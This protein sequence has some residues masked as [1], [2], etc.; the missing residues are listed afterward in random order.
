MDGHATSNTSGSSFASASTATGGTSTSSVTSSILAIPSDAAILQRLIK[1]GVPSEYLERGKDG[2][3]EYVKE[4]K[5]Q[6]SEVIAALLP[7]PDEVQAV[8]S[9][10]TDE[11][12]G[13]GTRKEFL[14]QCRDALKWVQWVMFQGEPQAVL[15][16]A[17]QGTGSTRGVCG[18]VWGSNDIAYRCRTCEHDPTCAICVPCF[19]NGNHASHDY[20]MIRTS[21]GCCDCGDVTA[22][23]Q[24]GFCSKH[25]GPGQVSQL[26]A[27]LVES[28]TPVLEAL[29]FQ[30][31]RT[32]KAAELVAE[33]K[34]KKWTAQSVDEKVACQLSVV[35]I[36]MLLEFCSFGEPMLAFTAEV[37]GNRSLGLVDTLMGTECFLP[38]RC[39]KHL[40]ELLYK[41]LGDTKFK[42]TFAQTFIS[43]YPACLRETFKEDAAVLGS[44]TRKKYREHSI[45]N[46]FSVQI[47]TVPTLTPKLVMEDGLLDMLLDT[48]KEFLRGCV[49]EDGRISVSKG[50]VVDRHYFRII[51]DI[52]YVMTHLE[53][54]R[55]V[56]RKRPELARAWLHLVAFVQ[57]MYPHRRITN[58]HV[59]D[60]TDIWGSAYSLE[61]QMAFIHPLFVGGAAVSSNLDPRSKDDLMSDSQ[62]DLA[63]SGSSDG[64]VFS[65]GNVN[66]VD[67]LQNINSEAGDTRTRVVDV[68]M[69]DA[70]LTADSI[71]DVS[72]ELSL[73]RRGKIE[74]ETV[75][76][77]GV[78]VSA[79]L[80]WFV[81]ECAQ[82]L[83]TWLSL[84]ASRESVKSGQLAIDASQISGIR[85]STRW[86]GRGGRGI[87]D[88]P[89]Q[90]TGGQIR[91]WL[92]RSRRL[93]FEP[94][95]WPEAATQEQ[96]AMGTNSG[97]QVADMDVEMQAPGEGFDNRAAEWW[98]GPEGLTTSNI[99]DQSVEV[100]EWPLVDF[101]V[102]RQD[103]SFHIPLHRMLALLLHK[104][105]EFHSAKQDKSFGKEKILSSDGTSG[106][107]RSF[108]EQ[109]LPRKFRVPGFAAVVMEHPL[110]LQVLC[111]QVQA[112]M[113]RRNGH[114]TRALCDLYHSVHWCEDSLE[115]DL[116][117]LQCC[118]V[119]APCEAFVDRIVARFALSDYFNFSFW[120][121]NEY[122]VTLAQELIILLIR[123]VSER[124]FCGLTEKESLR[125][126]LV[127][128][129]AVGDTTRSYL[130]KALP[131]RL[132]DSKHL[133]ECLDAVATYRNP[134]GM[135][136]GKYALRD[137]CWCELDLYHPR[138]SPRELQ[139]AEERYLRACRSPAVF[140]QLPRWSPP[141]AAL[142]G[143]G[144]LITS[145]RVHDMLR[146]IFFHAVYTDDP[147][148]SRAPEELLLYALHLLAL[149]LDVCKSPNNIGGERR[150]DLLGNNRP[151]SDIENS[152]SSSVK[153]HPPLLLRC[154][155]KVAVGRANTLVA[156]E[157]QSMLSLL[158][159]LLRK[160]RNDGASEAGSYGF[161]DLIKKLLRSF[162][163]L[164]SICMYEIELLAPEVLHRV[165]V[166]ITPKIDGTGGIDSKDVSVSESDRRKSIARERQAAAMAKMKA[167]QESFVVNYKPTEESSNLGDGDEAEA[168]RPKESRGESDEL[169]EDVQF[170][171][172][173]L[174][175]DAASASPLC[176]MVLVQRS[177]LL[178]I[179]E[180]PTP[181]WKRSLVT[182]DQVE[183][184]GESSDGVNAA[185]GV[186]SDGSRYLNS[187]AELWHWI[188]EA[189]GDAQT[190]P[191]L[192]DDEDVLELLRN[193]PGVRDTFHV[194]PEP[195]LSWD[196]AT[197]ISLDTVSEEVESG[198][199][200]AEYEND[201]EAGSVNV[202]WWE[203]NHSRVNQ[204]ES[205]T[206]R[207]KAV[208]TVLAEYVAAAVC[209]GQSRP[210]ER[211]RYGRSES[212]GHTGPEQ[213]RE[214]LTRSRRATARIPLSM[215]EAI[216]YKNSDT[217]GVHMSACGHAIHQDCRDRYFSSLLQRFYSRALFEGVQIVDLDMGE[218]LCPV[219]RR[220]ANAILPVLP[221]QTGLNS[222][223]IS[224][225]V[226]QLSSGVSSST[227]SLQVD[228]ALRLL[229]KA[230]ELVSRSE[231]RK[232]ADPQLPYNVKVVLEDLAKR[233]CGL[234]YSEKDLFTSLSSIQGHVHQGLLL[235]NVFR[236]SLM[237][238]EL[239]S[240]SQKLSENNGNGLMALIEM[241]EASHGSVLPLLLH[242]AKA[243]QSQSR[244][245]VLLR[246]RGM[247]LLV[248]SIVNGIS[249]D[250]HA[251]D[252]PR[253]LHGNYSALMQYLEKDNDSVD[254]QLWKRL[255]DP[256]LVHDA[257]SS[258][259]WLLFCLPLPFPA[260]G[261]PFI[262]L[263]H[264]F[265][266]VTI[267]QTIAQL[268][269]FATSGTELTPSARSFI[270]AVQTGSNGTVLESSTGDS[271][272]SP[273]LE[274]YLAYIRRCT[275][276]FLRRCYLLQ[277][278]L[279]GAAQV[280]PVATAHQWELPQG[281]IHSTET[282][283][284][285]ED[286]KDA[287]K[288]VLLE[289]EELDQLESVFLIPSLVN[290]FEQ[291]TNQ[292][293]VQAWC[294]H[295]KTDAGPRGIQH[296][297]R[298]TTASPFKLMQLPY[299]FQDLMQRYVKEKCPRCKTVPDK[300]AICLMC[301]ALCCA[302]SLRP[303][304]SV[305]RQGECTRHAMNCGAGIGIFLML[306]KTNILLLRCGRQAMWP[307]PYLDAFGE[308]DLELRRGK[309]LYLSRERYA[310]LTNMVVAHGLD[311]SSPVLSHT[312]R[313]IPF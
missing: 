1:C 60:E 133:Q 224:P 188:Q 109:V 244:L 223:F 309:P 192:L 204:G 46:S 298:V 107:W 118:A 295:V 67:G 18:A 48:L 305:N 209:R 149:A 97:N 17:G 32:L 203:D 139:A 290:I 186:A 5:P 116:F 194:T 257:F 237:S 263:L 128:R 216:R 200:I 243:T 78:Q 114:A 167:A 215:S 7:G 189:L 258:F 34:A 70:V 185:S 161:R 172:C 178:A 245:S 19:Q 160:P 13:P 253:D 256:V 182:L 265:Y 80:V 49:G 261:A 280:L 84:D 241:S 92:Q 45:V 101:D 51:D 162:A 10:G 9:S 269:S 71:D 85:R 74:F 124:G 142:Q 252:I 141:F 184:D 52:R 59:E 42:H 212:P 176:F 234:F 208:A 72:T 64:V 50:P 153:E 242:A 282:E 120:H 193:G 287:D 303:C 308:E 151:F 61:S 123:L 183:R 164:D 148:N 38:D 106:E 28:A 299:L 276:P 21:G 105:L 111:A 115:I 197:A 152:S 82:V 65:N 169:C 266:L 37:V 277:N 125:R 87:R 222:S 147:S 15:A 146:S 313:D 292:Q 206:K 168:K 284:T 2:I 31:I 270:A 310:A 30:W 250:N 99:L 57:G 47:F 246:A 110:R 41:L 58:T 156:P 137:E 12:Q 191:R 274:S 66:A 121:P 54:S 225:S 247:Q 117:L 177:K 83:V 62:G 301:G 226:A 306:R 100:D 76:I 288:Q 16:A 302:F 35:C 221:G 210:Q 131:P 296:S 20:S 238:S 181:S 130:L 6:V 281:H 86:R 230:E 3:A 4:H 271:S 190:Q 207:D 166:G 187:T 275:L 236:Y 90:T 91:V 235:W 268:G 8:T 55:Y 159:L 112:G 126:E 145:S 170:T 254:V 102:S 33:N 293:L 129:L 14:S 272:I 201:N 214:G 217:V 68:D 63:A 154:G 136:Q 211:T 219:C 155:E 260:N 233:L 228:H 43:H 108:L 165:S 44:L 89:T 198:S 40:Q 157:S 127:L 195:L 289:M 140:L 144:R 73:Q 304:C 77:A 267:V 94:R 113:W 171:H 158:V 278:L 175:R 39:V 134:S 75:F 27:S 213:L 25:C 135:Q 231:F 196:A 307:S 96:A 138:W 227:A 255:A 264:L 248:D 103:V 69:Y 53:V 205:S 286:S 174:C 294:K 36:E 202:N 285:S 240:R 199:E 22:W 132:Q 23:K 312:T 122:Q 163:E 93:P 179:A 232:V 220:L 239:A 150:E 29:L 173:A 88:S 279:S 98:M 95:V 119:L 81:S 104:A 283:T 311:Y 273:T 262:A 291:E 229:V 251:N 297:I 300:P 218:F 26:P 79:S 249:R 56:A 180:K 11:V 259:T 24:S 143:L